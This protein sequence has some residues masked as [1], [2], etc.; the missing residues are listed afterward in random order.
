MGIRDYLITDPVVKRVRRLAQLE[1]R[2]AEESAKR[3][4]AIRAA[5]ELT[6]EYDALRAELKNLRKTGHAEAKSVR[7][8]GVD[9]SK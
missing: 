2:I 9:A 8:S 4:A 5:E 3:R 6:R 7:V 1:E